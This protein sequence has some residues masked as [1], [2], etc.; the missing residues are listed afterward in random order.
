MDL[1]DKN[2]NREQ[3][4]ASGPESAYAAAGRRHARRT[5]ARHPRR[6]P[7]HVQPLRAAVRSAAQ[8]R[9]VLR[10][11][12][13]IAPPADLLFRPYRDLLRQQAGAGRGRRAAHRPAP[14]VDVRDR[15]RRNELGRP[16]RRALRLAVGRRGA[17]VPR[18]GA[19]TRRRP[20]RHAAAERR[21]RLGQPVVGDRDGHRARTHPPGDFVGAD[22]PAPAGLRAAAAGV[23]AVPRARRSAGQRTGRGSGAARG[24][25]P[26]SRRT[27]VLRLGQRVRPARSRRAGVSRVALP[28]QQRRVP[29]F[30]RRRRLPR[31]HPVERRRA[32]VAAFRRRRTPDL[33]GAR[34]AGLGAAPDVRGSDHAVGLAGRDQRARGARVL[35]LGRAPQRRSGAAADRGRVAGAAPGRRPRRRA[36]AGAGRGQPGARSLGVVVSGDTF[37]PR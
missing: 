4:D 1:I 33:L 25:R 13:R 30:R 8:R 12:D 19:R 26:R 5:A 32:G 27:V 17:R 11:A 14:G 3:R 23:G 28:G 24:A 35:R 15:R 34:R 31:R 2:A 10:Q 37:C 20:D 22:P 18:A 16:E 21:H 29:R 7:R 9:G 36:A 6:L